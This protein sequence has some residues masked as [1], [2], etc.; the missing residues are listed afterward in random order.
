MAI[1]E[2]FADSFKFIVCNSGGFDM[3]VALAVETRDILRFWDNTFPSARI[4]SLFPGDNKR[5]LK[6]L[7]MSHPE[8][9]FYNDSC[10]QK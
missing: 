7:K 8:I 6:W 5:E 2:S 10:L 1:K 4:Q 3:G 9:F